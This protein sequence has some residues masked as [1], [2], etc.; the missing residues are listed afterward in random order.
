M[1]SGG[2]VGRHRTGHQLRHDVRREP[3]EADG[4]AGAIAEPVAEGRRERPRVA[5]LAA[6]L[7]DDQTRPG[8]SASVHEVGEDLL[9]GGVRPLHVIHDEHAR[10]NA[11]GGGHRPGEAV[12]EPAL[13]PGPVDRW[14]LGVGRTEL[15]DQSGRLA[16]HR[17]RESGEHV[18]RR[19]VR[20]RQAKQVGDGPV[21]HVAIVVVAA[22]HQRRAVKPRDDLLDQTGLAHPR[23]ALD[24]DH[25][26]GTDRGEQRLDLMVATD[27][28]VAA[29]HRVAEGLVRGIRRQSDVPRGDRLVE[30]GR[31]RERGHSELLVDRANALAVLVHG[32]GPV[33][34][35][36]VQPHQG[37]VGRLVQPVQPQPSLGVGDRLVDLAGGG[38]G[39]HESTA[40]RGHHPPQPLGLPR[41]PIIEVGAV[42]EA[43][44][45][46]TDP[47]A[48][49]R[50][51]APPPPGRCH[52]R[53]RG[54]PGRRSP[55]R[56]RR[57]APPHL[58]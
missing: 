42:A 35:L 21:G 51:P 19:R 30:R 5:H 46:P 36:R 9:G 52:R 14:R 55:R 18:A 11:A 6:A 13:A 20:D 33:A 40:R 50:R 28:R 3:P 17:A 8:V 48:T 49:E 29:D 37:A 38:A 23:L 4:D 1:I 10:R 7:R 56:R 47:R 44:T 45:L 22:R 32:R 39:L 15:R 16:R 58:S 25:A 31:L 2:V 54:R 57:G 34:A 24:H 27:Q 43:E 12:E 41:L 53:R 26:T